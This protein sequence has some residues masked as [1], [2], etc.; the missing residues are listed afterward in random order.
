MP[1]GRKPNDLVRPPS[2][3]RMWNATSV[4]NDVYG[5]GPPRRNA[6]NPH[7]H[8]RGK[9]R[10]H[11]MI[12]FLA[13]D[14][15]PPSAKKPIARPEWQVRSG[16]YRVFYRIADAVLTIIIVYAGRRREI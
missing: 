16:D 14:A 1:H 15:R 4:W 6:R 11:A 9:R 5:S 12:E 2:P 7:A 3:G 8:S 13:V 10:V